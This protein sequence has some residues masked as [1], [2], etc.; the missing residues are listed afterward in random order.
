MLGQRGLAGVGMRDDRESPPS[1]RLGSKRVAHAAGI[2]ERGELVIPARAA[3]YDAI[4]RSMIGIGELEQAASPGGGMRRILPGK[5]ARY[6]TSL[7]Q[8]CE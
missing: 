3:S 5:A 6:V 4:A 1:R 2:Q 7:R 8:S